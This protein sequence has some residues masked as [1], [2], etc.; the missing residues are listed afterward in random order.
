[1]RELW[2]NS[3]KRICGQRDHV[4]RGQHDCVSHGPVDWTARHTLPP[5]PLLPPQVPCCPFRHLLVSL[6]HGP[7]VRGW[8]TWALHC[9]GGWVSGARSFISTAEVCADGCGVLAPEPWPALRPPRTCPAPLQDPADPYRLDYDS[10]RTL[11]LTDQG[12]EP[13]DVELQRLQ[14]VCLRGGRG[15]CPTC[16]THVLL[17][18]PPL[19]LH[20]PCLAPTLTPEYRLA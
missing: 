16:P 18:S 13:M 4:S 12:S 1:M 9:R 3:P 10:E 5:P 20:P 6:P 15:V 7:A 19:A 8:S 17:P 14:E 11:M 2:E